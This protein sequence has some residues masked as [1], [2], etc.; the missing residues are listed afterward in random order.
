MT[1]GKVIVV[2]EDRRELKA[3]AAALRADCRAL[4][5]DARAIK[6]G[7]CANAAGKTKHCGRKLDK[8]DDGPGGRR[9]HDGGGSAG[10][11]LE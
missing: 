10:D 9:L 1:A 11:G 8:S 2:I 5:A 6:A 3:W 4:A 7:S